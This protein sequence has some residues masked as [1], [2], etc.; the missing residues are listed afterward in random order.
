[1]TSEKTMTPLRT[2]F[3]DRCPEHWNTEIAAL[4]GVSILQTAEWG[5]L[6][7]E[8]GWT[9]RYARAY[10]AD[11]VLVAAALILRKKLFG[12]LEMRY[13]PR[14]PLYDAGDLATAEAFYA[15][16]EADAKA[17]GSVLIKT[18]RDFPIATGV[19]GT[20]TYREDAD[21]MALLA[22]LKRR[23]YRFSD[24]QIQF[25]NS[26]W[27]DLTP[28]EETLMM[29]MK[30]RTR[31]KARLALKRG[32]EIRSGTPDDFEMIAG[33]YRETADRDGFIIREKSYY[34]NVWNRFYD[35]GMLTP[36]IAEV[37]GEAVAVLQLFVFARKAWYIYGMSS[38]KHR[39]KMP[40]YALQWEAI[41]TAKA[42]GA[43]VYDLW[44]APDVFD[45]SDRMWGVYQFKRGLGGIEVLSPGAYDLPL[46][47]LL[48][49]G[50]VWA[51]AAVTGL[52]RLLYRLKHRGQSAPV[53][54]EES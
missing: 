20:D 24:S 6:K 9:P 18:D 10:N 19:P 33:M 4:D 36:L 31:Y 23:G 15:A 7:G 43:L 52:R 44:G 11:A 28:D 34:L 1:M 2:V 46:R 5:A 45:E 35:A 51:L 22:M 40:N 41:R 37:D 30:Q 29:N 32:V 50:Y 14:G 8:T 26:V 13:V 21:G 49:R 27:I 25:A 47:P 16:L 48:Y 42:Q 53:V 38:G 12:P 54:G 17:G 39:E 3:D